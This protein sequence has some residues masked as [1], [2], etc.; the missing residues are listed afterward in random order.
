MSG[1]D[2]FDYLA[3]LKSPPNQRR[4]RSLS[5]T[6][7]KNSSEKRRPKKIQKNE[8]INKNSGNKLLPLKVKTPVGKSPDTRPVTTLSR[9]NLEEKYDS[10]D[11]EIQNISSISCTELDFNKPP[12]TKK[13]ASPGMSDSD[14][15]LDFTPEKNRQDENVHKTLNTRLLSLVSF[16]SPTTCSKSVRPG[17]LADKLHKILDQ[18]R[19]ENVKILQSIRPVPVGANEKKIIVIST[20]SIAADT[21]MVKFKFMDTAGNSIEDGKENFM[22]LSSK[23]YED[24]LQSHKQ[25]IVKVEHT[26]ETDA[27]TFMHYVSHLRAC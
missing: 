8:S 7:S 27:K 6:R 25:F 10:S 13:E 9:T 17:G 3:S 24:L 19:A 2:K 14:N 12:M 21:V 20:L 5:K 18:R 15:L 23:I 1:F 11:D 16:R 26:V 4:K 22:S